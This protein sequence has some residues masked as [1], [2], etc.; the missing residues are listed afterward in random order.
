[1]K[2]RA[3]VLL[4]VAFV[5]VPLSA[6]ADPQEVL[7]D[8]WALPSGGQPQV[9]SFVVPY[10]MPV[11]VEV[12]PVS[13]ADKGVTLALLPAEDLDACT[14]KVQG[15][16]RALP[17]FNSSAVRSF[18]HTESIPA[19]RWAFLAA[20]TE[21]LLFSAT[22]HV[23]VVM[24]PPLL[25]DAGDAHVSVD[26]TNSVGTVW[27]ASRKFIA[28][29][30]LGPSESTPSGGHMSPQVLQFVRYDPNDKTPKGER[31]TASSVLAIVRAVP[32]ESQVTVTVFPPASKAVVNG[33]CH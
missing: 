4:V 2:V 26:E 14:G 3:F 15:I 17:G 13:H 19:G 30:V 9:L 10:A 24:V 25:C 21:N 20:N 11:T 29:V 27:T 22:V 5:L 12:T 1:M 31:L 18:S 23:H 7:N 8:N 28:N 6:L 33:I 16:C 32:G